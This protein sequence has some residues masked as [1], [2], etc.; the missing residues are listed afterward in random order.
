M[1]KKFLVF[2]LIL[3]FLIPM[4]KQ[5][6]GDASIF[7]IPLKEFKSVT[8]FTSKQLIPNYHLLEM[9]IVLP[10]ED[11]NETETINMIKRISRIDS[12]ILQALVSEDIQIMLF[13][14]Q[15]TDQPSASH[16]KGMKPRGYSVQGPYWDDVPGIGGSSS[17]LV[18]I[19][20]S[21]KGNGHGSENLELH[22]IAHTV[23]QKV[24][25]MIRYD[26]NF[27]KVWKEEAGNLFPKQSYF[28]NYPEEYFAEAFVYYFLSNNTREELKKKAPLTYAYFI[29]IF[30]L[31][32]TNYSALDDL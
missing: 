17:V 7:G 21:H 22:E 12:H 5:N 28:I 31:L 15:L 8:F 25:Q 30:T 32:G 6:H 2:S 18:K 23:D 27:Q 26:E 4:D 11:F 9:L 24:F 1:K 16:L 19:G 14:G 13:T 29:E 3:I 10:E 20:H